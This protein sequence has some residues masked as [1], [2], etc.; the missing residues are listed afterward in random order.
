M[1]RSTRSVRYY[2]TRLGICQVVALLIA[3]GS[4]AAEIGLK[5]GDTVGPQNWQ[6]VKGMV[7][8][9]LLERIKRGYSF[10][11]KAPTRYQPPREYLEATRKYASKVRL[12]ADGELLG[13]R[14]GLP[15]PEIDPS[16]PQAGL[17]I[18][19][20]FYWRWQGDDFETGGGSEAGRVVR[21]AIEKDGS[22][23][24][25]DF[26]SYFL[27][28][29]TRVTLDPKP[30]IRGFEHIDSIQLR[31]DQ[32]PRDTAGTGLLEIRYTDPDRPDDLYLYIPSL[33]RI[34]RL[35]S[36][37]RCLTLAPSEFNLDDIDFFKGKITDFNYRL[38]GEKKALVNYAQTNIPY[39]RKKGDYLPSD[40]DWEVQ[41]VY[42]LEITP[43][44]PD[45]CYPK[46]IL[47]LDKV[48]WE[49]TWGMTW[50]KNG[51][52]WKEMTL[53]RMPAKLPDGQV[54]WQLGTGFIVNVQ[55]GRSTVL[56][57]TKLYNQGF[58]PSLF[59]L[60]TMQRFMR[61]GTVK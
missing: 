21:Y 52:Y 36:T 10:K 54:V 61:G 32:Y 42:V 22:E 34:R 23:R 37:Q 18:A 4:E 8:D 55:N 43:K 51:S 1:G 31:L 46:K 44:D 60:E 49:P 33:R 38:L 12:G 59:T 40:E 47:W 14:A 35:S 30:V 28:P 26:V 16:D 20:N 29:R 57:T 27:F 56:T 7:G 25:A 3:F 48:A 17:K 5:P 41:D 45:Y 2:I 13:H 58:P 39:H 6:T 50:D 9:N 19:W 11:I 15:F 24:R 53:F